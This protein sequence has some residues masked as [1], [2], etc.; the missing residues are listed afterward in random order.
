MLARLHYIERV[1]KLSVVKA[2]QRGPGR[3][4]FF[5]IR[6]DLTNGF[7]LVLSY[8]ASLVK[9]ATCAAQVARPKIL[10]PA[11]E[12]KG[13][14]KWAIYMLNLRLCHL[15]SSVALSIETLTRSG[16]LCRFV[17]VFAFIQQV[18]AVGHN[19]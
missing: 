10:A 18:L 19:G 3:W 2:E 15:A 8:Q 12:S 14:R 9:S 6:V 4:L 11:I 16:R 5:L 7:C 1:P 13:A 17:D